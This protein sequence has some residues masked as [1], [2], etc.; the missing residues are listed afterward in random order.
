MCPTQTMVWIL[1]QASRPPR[2]ATFF[3]TI[4][5]ADR[6]A[7]A[8]QPFEA[9][10]ATVIPA[11][12]A[13]TT[14]KRM[15]RLLTSNTNRHAFPRGLLRLR[16]QEQGVIQ[17]RIQAH[18]FDHHLVGVLVPLDR[19]LEHEGNH[20]ALHGPEIALVDKHR[21]HAAIHAARR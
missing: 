4:W 10:A 17:D 5:A 20:Q 7:S 21:V 8:A 16:P 14:L 13:A 1:R 12:S 11:A 3:S 15:G 19:G 9:S 18:L 2:A 6:S